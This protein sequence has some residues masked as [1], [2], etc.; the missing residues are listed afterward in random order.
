[1][2]YEVPVVKQPLRRG[3]RRLASVRIPQLAG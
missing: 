2:V 3:L 1:M